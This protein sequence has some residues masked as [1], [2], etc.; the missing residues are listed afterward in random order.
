M[1]RV[2]N[3]M[4]THRLCPINSNRGFSWTRLTPASPLPVDLE[5]VG[6]CIWWFVCG[7]GY[8]SGYEFGGRA[9]DPEESCRKRSIRS[10]YG[11]LIFGGI[12]NL[13][14]LAESGQNSHSRQP[15]QASIEILKETGRKNGYQ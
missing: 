11:E 7:C 13:L 14:D 2:K 5:G 8:R 9:E 12:Y 15:K 10:E 3:W 6:E 1:K 4:L